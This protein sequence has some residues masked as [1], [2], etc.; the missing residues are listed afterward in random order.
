MQVRFGLPSPRIATKLYGTIA[1]LLAMVCLLAA[2]TIRFAD[3]TQA[4]IGRLRA[5]PLAQLAPAA[6]LHALMERHRR[7][8]AAAPVG[9]P[10]SLEREEMSYRALNADIADLIGQLPVERAPAH[11]HEFALLASLGSAVFDLARDRKRDQALAAAARHAEAAS[12]LAMDFAKEASQFSTGDDDA[13][14]TISSRA[15]SLSSRAWLIAGL[16]ALLIGPLGFL[17]LHRSLSRLQGIGSAL[18][19][20]ARNDISVEIADVAAQDEFGHLARSVAVFKAR[21]IELMSKNADFERLNLQ[22]DAAINNM[23]LGLTMFDAHERLIVCNRRY[24]EMY[25]VPAEMTQRGTAHC[26]LW[27]QRTKRGARHS[28]QRADAVQGAVS[29]PS[30]IEF[31]N[32]R[33]ISVSRQPLKGGG[34]LSLHED[35]TERRRQEERITHLARHDPLTGLANRVLFLEQLEQCLQRSLR[36]QGFAVLSL[37]LD[38]FKAVNDTLGHPIG[39]A[40]LKQVGQRLI[41]C[42][43]HGDLAARLGGDEFA[44]IQTSV[45]DASQPESLAARIVEAIG[46][47]FEIDGKPVSI[48]T[49]IGITL[50]PRDGADADKLLKNADLALYRS[51]SAGR[52]GYAFFKT[53]MDEQLQSRRSLEVDL[54]RALAEEA[55]ELVYQPVV[56]LKSQQVIGFE[57]LPSWDHPERAAILPEQC[58]GIAEEMGLSAEVGEWTLL[59]ACAQAVQ[60]PEPCSIAVNISAAQFLKR[61]LI[62]CVLQALA[63]SGLPPRRLELEISE[64]VLLHESQNVLAMLHQLRQLGVRVVLDDFGAG[65]CSLA[66]L[67]AFPFDTIKLDKVLIAEAQRRE[68]SRAIVA[69][70]IALGRSL[71]VTTVAGGVDNPDQLAMVRASGCDHAQGHLLSPPVAAAEVQSLLA[72]PKASARVSADEPAR[73]SPECGGSGAPP[74]SSQAA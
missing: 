19:R 53:E 11:A 14:E 57:A 29:S 37:D 6:R 5:G 43:R 49:S 51:K 38:H 65:Y 15:R 41:A 63:Q 36:G 10:D 34:W 68:D 35:I 4:T 60:W 22:L 3:H 17:L 48:G 73:I 30:T 62:E 13:L 7:Q 72:E 58:I 18:N 59:H 66:H 20:L 42:V 46:A 55:L 12:S 39:D 16:T 47:P 61:S 8:V 70:V 69:S 50:A 67:R 45:C 24:T 44:V 26:V 23:P 28:E 71:G 52:R 21:S 74:G 1:L 33:T 31:G 64:T 9:A 2:G 27:E 54:R 25:E 40:L 56:C 32:G